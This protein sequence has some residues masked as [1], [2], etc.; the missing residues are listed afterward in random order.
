MD[1][2]RRVSRRVF[3]RR[4]HSIYLYQE[5]VAAAVH[6]EALQTIRCTCDD[7]ENTRL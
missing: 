3:C 4:Q 7:D 6:G 1:M 5:S 2:C